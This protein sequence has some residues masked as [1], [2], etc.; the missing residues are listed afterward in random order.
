MKILFVSGNRE[1]LPD[2]VIPLG[3]L[4]V[5][6]NTPDRHDKVLLDL[7]FEDDPFAALAEGISEHSPEL[8]ALSMRN[9]QN[10]DYTGLSDNLNYYAQLVATCK[11]KSTAPVVLGG[12]GFSVMP[13]ELMV[14]L[15][16]DYGISGEGEEA[17]PRLVDNL[18]AGK[19]ISQIGCLFFRDT[20]DPS[21]VLRGPTPPDFLD[22]NSLVTPDH[23]MA[24]SRYFGDYG[25]DSIQTKR[26][27]PLRCDYCTY[28]IIEGRKGRLRS[29]KS[30]VDEMCASAEKNPD[31]NH[32]F[33]VDSVFN[34]PKT[35]AKKVCREL[36][37]RNWEIPWSCYSNP[38]GFDQEFADLAYEAGCAGMEVG[39]DS[40]SDEILKQLHKGFTTEHIKKLNRICI[41]AGI[42]DC[43][44]FILGTEGETLDDSKRTLEF[45]AELDP[46]GAIIMVWTDDYDS[47][48]LAIREERLALRRQIEQLLLEQANDHPRW[49]MPG[50]GVNFSED[51]FDRLRAAGMYGPLWQHLRGPRQRNRRRRQA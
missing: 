16:A 44:T 18:E 40:G 7:C 11:H 19:D 29:A 17:F 3:L 36:I 2:A 12:A 46:F 35:H 23:S 25:M 1:K 30:V 45:L 39:S 21:K 10:N 51:L 41:Q 50:L 32:F 27:C 31:I 48:N 13:A 20:A 24:D 9:I 8:I 43:H 28:P 34:L 5:M 14:R 49:A 15:K 6:A 26:G 4:Y 22:M 37:A 33:I 42:P 38:L 47:L